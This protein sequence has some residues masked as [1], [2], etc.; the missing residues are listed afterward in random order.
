MIKQSSSSQVRPR[1]LV[2]PFVSVFIYLRF[3]TFCLFCQ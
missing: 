1:A 2:A 3:T